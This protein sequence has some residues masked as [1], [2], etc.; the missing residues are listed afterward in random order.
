[1]TSE[2]GLVSCKLISN[3]FV[4]DAE[5]EIFLRSLIYNSSLDSIQCLDYLSPI[6]LLWVKHVNEQLS[7]FWKLFRAKKSVQCY[8]LIRDVA[9]C[10]EEGK[11]LAEKT[12]LSDYEVRELFPVKDVHDLY[13]SCVLF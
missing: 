12:G 1:M 8:T 3:T 7:Q 6:A 9:R 13:F 5:M 4:L 11:S 10:Y 2:D